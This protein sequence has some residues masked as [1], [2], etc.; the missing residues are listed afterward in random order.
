[1]K[2][3]L[4]ACIICSAALLTACDDSVIDSDSIDQSATDKTVEETPKSYVTFD[5]TNGK[6]STPTDILKNSTTGLLSNITSSG[7]IYDSLRSLDG[8][9]LGSPFTVGVS[10]PSKTYGSITLKSDSVAAADAVL[11]RE[12]DGG[13]LTYGTDF[14]TKATSSGV[15]IVPLKALKESTTYYVAVLDNVTDSLGRAVESSSTYTTLKTTYQTAPTALTAT[16]TALAQL[17]LNAEGQFSSDVSSGDS[18]IY[19]TQFTTQSVSPVMQHVMDQIDSAA[20]QISSVVNAQTAF[21]L[22]NI[23]ISD[24]KLSTFLVASGRSSTEAAAATSSNDPTVYFG[25]LTVP[26]FLDTPEGNST[27][28]AQLQATRICDAITSNWKA[29]DGGTLRPADDNPLK[30]SD[31][32]VQVFITIPDGTMPSSGWPVALYVHGITSFK[33]TVA[34]IAGN[35]AAQGIATVSIDLPLHGARSVDYDN[36]NV[37]DISATD[38]DNGGAYA[39]GSSLVFANL[40]ALRTVRDNL[41]QSIS[42]NLSLRMALTNTSSYASGS[43]NLDGNSVSL[44]G[45]SLGSIIG[46]GVLG[47][48]DVFDGDQS[49]LDF[50]SAVLTV[51]GTQA[52]PI[53]GYSNEF[54]PTVKTALK[55][56]DGF[57]ESVA[58][59]LGYTGTELKALRDGTSSQKTTYDRLAE[60][61]Y[62]SFLSSFVAGAQQAIDS[63]D[64]LAWA[65]NVSSSTPVL[66]TEIVGNGTNLSDQVVPNSTSSNGFPLGGT[67][68]LISSLGLTTYSTDQTGSALKAATKFLVGHHTSLLNSSEVTNVTQD[69]SSALAATVEMQTQVITFL[70][71][72]GQLLDITNSNVIQ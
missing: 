64:S 1:M 65:A 32:S 68:A 51:G 63:G 8:W 28:A 16:Q 24:S 60:L 49:K 7:D 27:C 66:V 61:A 71:S 72:N 48:S 9:G 21:G 44:L 42:D 62:S 67:N 15:T 2:K 4:L 26:Y 41:R 17:I 30:Q 47:A 58:P 14:I 46:T 53:M 57:A 50:D 13:R 36:D 54:G 23:T 18:I 69:A 31:D 3:P 22:N 55:A 38:S 34:G 45:V 40:G 43:F 29:S 37:Y 33:E 39:N 12:K 56:S 11:I 52:A 20:P 35:L 19:A 6:L 10:F 59:L 70:K 5:P 25:S